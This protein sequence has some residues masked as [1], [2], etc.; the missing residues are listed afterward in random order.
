MSRRKGEPTG[1]QIDRTHPHQ[2]GIPDH[3]VMGA[4]YE[5]VHGFCKGLSLHNR[6]QTVFAG[7]AGPRGCYFIIFCFAEKE[8]AELFAAEFEGIPFDPKRDRG[9]G[10]RKRFWDVAPTGSLRTGCGET[11]RS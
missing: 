5:V 3:K 2:V 1:A 7:W 6:T 4:N 9:K 8:D 10:K 11:L